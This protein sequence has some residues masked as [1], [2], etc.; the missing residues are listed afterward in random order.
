MKG[1]IPQVCEYYHSLKLMGSEI[2]GGLEIQKNPKQSQTPEIWRG[3]MLILRVSTSKGPQTAP[4][5]R[6]SGPMVLKRS[7]SFRAMSSNEWHANGR[8]AR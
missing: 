8:N 6:A 2:P 3:L 5:P 7:N 1:W 4:P